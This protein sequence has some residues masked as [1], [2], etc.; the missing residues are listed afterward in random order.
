MQP[1]ETEEE[2]KKLIEADDWMMGI[3]KTVESLQLP[4]SW[5]CAGFIRSKVW[6]VLHEKEYRTPLA[7]IDVIYFDKVNSLENFEKQY[8]QK[9]QQYLPNEPWSVKNQARMHVINNSE[10]YQSSIDGIANFPEIPTAIGV[11]LA[12][13]IL[14]LAA[15]HGIK[16]LMSGIV[17]PTPYFQKGSQMHEVY[18]KR[19]Q[20]KQWK[21]IWPKLQIIY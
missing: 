3:L 8:E 17:A 16:H 13:G 19:V 1:I 5:I 6:D 7:D 2:L 12:N 10:P 4:D 15:P 21:S 20:S 14:E 18:E 9:L 11:R